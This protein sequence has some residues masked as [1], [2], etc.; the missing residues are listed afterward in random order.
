MI[1]LHLKVLIANIPK[2]LPSR[3]YHLFILGVIFCFDRKWI[4][5]KASNRNEIWG[6]LSLG[7]F[8]CSSV[9]FSLA[10]CSLPGRELHVSH[11]VL[12]VESTE[13]MRTIIS[14]KW[15]E[16]QNKTTKWKNKQQKKTLTKHKTHPQLHIIFFVFHITDI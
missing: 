6:M 3:L 7:H 1:C 9:S 12:L 4:S 16:K 2:L 8:D 10:E 5:H 13:R 15:K 11:L 14:S